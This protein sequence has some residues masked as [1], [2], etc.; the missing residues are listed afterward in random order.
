MKK[1]SKKVTEAAGEAD[2]NYS[3]LMN[4]KKAKEPEPFQDDGDSLQKRLGIDDPG[5]QRGNRTGSSS[6]TLKQIL[7][8]M[9]DEIRAKKKL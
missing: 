5:Y 2:T 8:N 4:K 9:L 3:K 6:W 7:K 1:R